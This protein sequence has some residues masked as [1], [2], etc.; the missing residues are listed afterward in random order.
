MFFHEMKLSWHCPAL[1]VS[2]HSVFPSPDSEVSNPPFPQ[3]H[4]EPFG[5]FHNLDAVAEGIT[6]RI[7]DQLCFV[8]SLCLQ[9]AKSESHQD[10]SASSFVI[11]CLSKPWQ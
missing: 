4:R 7:P 1:S 11:N 3:V 10:S 8:S 9:T 6:A 5:C 2:T